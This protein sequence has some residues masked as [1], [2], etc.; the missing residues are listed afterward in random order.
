MIYKDKRPTKIYP[1]RRPMPAPQEP[2]PPAD[3]VINQPPTQPE[4]PVI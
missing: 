1:E 4:P 3:M 2:Q